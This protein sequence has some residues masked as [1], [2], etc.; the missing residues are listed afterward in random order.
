M[1][2]SKDDV[3]NVAMLARLSFDDDKLQKMQTELSAIID[4]ADALQS[5]NTDDV[6]PLFNV[7]DKNAP[8][9]EDKVVMMNNRN[10]VLQ[11]APDSDDNDDILNRQFFAVPKMIE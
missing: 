9:R 5:V 3:K 4:W 6:E 8:M 10:D 1:S 7:S 11:N 2:F